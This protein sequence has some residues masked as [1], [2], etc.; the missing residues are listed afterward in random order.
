MPS[1]QFSVVMPDWESVG[2][3]LVCLR[4]LLDLIAIYRYHYLRK[5]YFCLPN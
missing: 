5:H 1:G 3:K 2:R 4:K